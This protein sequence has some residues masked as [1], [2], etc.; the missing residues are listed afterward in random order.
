MLIYQGLLSLSIRS[1]PLR[2]RHRVPLGA[3]GTPRRGQQRQVPVA[4]LQQFWPLHGGPKE[5]SQRVFLVPGTTTT[6]V[7]N[8]GC[9]M[10]IYGES[11]AKNLCK[12]TFEAGW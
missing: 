8:Y 4:A 2:S 1:H 3:P 6:Q 10:A 5:G 9:L 11:M 7:A 12:S